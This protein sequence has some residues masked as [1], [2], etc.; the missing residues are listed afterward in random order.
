MSTTP[1]Q[2]STHISP[3]EDSKVP[4]QE[5]QTLLQI[6]RERDEADEQRCQECGLED[7]DKILSFAL[8]NKLMTFIY[9]NVLNPGIDNQTKNEILALALPNKAINLKIC[10]NCLI[11][12]LV[13]K[14]LN[15]LIDIPPSSE[16]DNKTNNGIPCNEIFN[17]SDKSKKFLLSFHWI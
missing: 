11:K 8:S 4:L 3:S 5:N 12:T 9:E 6:K 17:N 13:T 10:K 1:K 2:E 16:Q 14:G 7:K 15:Y